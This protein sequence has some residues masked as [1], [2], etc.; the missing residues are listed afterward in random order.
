LYA[1]VRGGQ[2]VA[3]NGTD[4]IE[5]YRR[6]IDANPWQNVGLKAAE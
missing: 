4:W 1:G 2:I 5:A 6:E 3:P